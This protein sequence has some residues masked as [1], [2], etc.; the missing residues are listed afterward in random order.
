MPGNSFTF[1]G[2]SSGVPQANRACS[3]HILKIGESLNLI[4]CGGG[5]CSSFLR[6][7]FDPLNVDRIFISHSHPDHVCELSLFIQMIYLAGRTAPVE[8]YLPEEFVEPFESYLRSVYLI[9]ARMPFELRTTGYGEGLLYDGAFSLRAIENT[10]LHKYAHHI[11]SLMLPNRMQCYSFDL[12]TGEKS[13]FY[14]GDIGAYDDL[15]SHLDGH[16]FV[17]LEAVHFD[18]AEFL[19]H[20]PTIKAGK[21]VITHVSSDESAAEIEAAA[22][23]AGLTN[24]EMARDGM[25]LPL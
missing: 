23:A 18:F 10:H 15:K 2:T 11:K 19:L 3:G 13:L 6:C 5:V 7:G 4:D 9:R 21:F 17:V 24:L 25:I 12:Q 16:D 1:L 14:S 20:A 22:H 8:V